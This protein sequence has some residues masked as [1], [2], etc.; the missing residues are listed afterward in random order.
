MAELA[1]QGI[2][3][4][5]VEAVVTRVD[6]TVEDHGTV[7]EWYVSEEE[8]TIPIYWKFLD[9]VFRSKQ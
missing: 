4:I 5:S 8:P 2:E 3:S 9:H 6:G 7:A 1:E